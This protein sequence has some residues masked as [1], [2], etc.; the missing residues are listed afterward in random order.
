MKPGSFLGY[1]F[2]VSK[3]EESLKMVRKHAILPEL[4]LE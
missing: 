2:L 4:E 3:G 1:F